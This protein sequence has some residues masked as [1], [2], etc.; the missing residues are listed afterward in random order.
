MNNKTKK[1]L[2]RCRKILTINLSIFRINR[3]NHK[4]TIKIKNHKKLIKTKNKYKCLIKKHKHLLK[5]SSIRKI[6]SKLN[7]LRFLYS[8]KKINLQKIILKIFYRSISLMTQLMSFILKMLTKVMI[9]FK[10]SLCKPLPL[11][12]LYS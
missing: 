1:S 5:N 10:W 4:H 3:I 8:F 7:I 11:K 9:F 2:K 6:N 12:K